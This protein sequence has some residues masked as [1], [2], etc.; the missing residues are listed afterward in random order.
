MINNEDKME[1][2]VRIKQFGGSIQDADLEQNFFDSEKFFLDTKDL[3][4]FSHFMK[5]GNFDE[6]E[7]DFSTKS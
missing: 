7:D 1:I 6:D 3:K 2:S 4:G 5:V